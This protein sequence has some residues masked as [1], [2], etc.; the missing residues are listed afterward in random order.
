MNDLVGGLKPNSGL[1][2]HVLTSPFFDA[3][4]AIREHGGARLQ[5]TREALHQQ[6][7][8][9]NR[10]EPKLDGDETKL[11]RTYLRT[12]GTAMMPTM[13][14]QQATAWLNAVVLKLSDLPPRCV[15]QAACEAVHQAFAYIAE[16]EQFIRRRGDE[17]HREQ[18]RAI[19]RLDRM[20]Q[21]L[22][23]MQQELRRAAMPDLPQLEDH[24]EP[25]ETHQVHEW[26]RTALGRSIVRLGLAAG[27]IEPHQLA[28]PLPPAE[29]RGA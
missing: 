18:Q 5:A 4:A 13:G 23:L 6:L 12:I 25:V 22:D 20:Q 10:F 8:P 26:Q 27:F 16:A 2:Q 21:E 1:A 19:A 3:R 11:L 29:E 15:Q 17:L 24:R 28:E 14:P 7:A 9:L